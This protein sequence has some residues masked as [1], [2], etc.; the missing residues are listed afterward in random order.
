ME[1]ERALPAA[2]HRGQRHG[3]AGPAQELKS[4]AGPAFTLRAADADAGFVDFV[5]HQ[6]LD[7]VDAR[8]AFLA[9]VLLDDPLGY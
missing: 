8:Q 2:R 7:L 6:H 4:F 1:T 5:L 3:F 9:D